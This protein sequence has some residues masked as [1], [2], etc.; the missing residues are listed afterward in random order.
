MG[1]MERVANLALVFCSKEFGGP[2]LPSGWAVFLNEAALTVLQ[3]PLMKT[4]SAHGSSWVTLTGPSPN[5]Q[6]L[7]QSLV[8]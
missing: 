6:C 5:Y 7:T 8:S 2:C 3:E 4:V 1:T